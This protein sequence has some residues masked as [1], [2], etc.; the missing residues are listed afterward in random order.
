MER[1]HPLRLL[2]L[3]LQANLAAALAK[4][5][6]SLGSN[7]L[8]ASMAAAFPFPD[9]LFEGNEKLAL[10]GT[11]CRS[12]RQNFYHCRTTATGEMTVRGTNPAQLADR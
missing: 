2:R 3:R 4:Q 9:A 1:P 6:D 12:L 7:S 5:Y 11:I 10:S 8:A